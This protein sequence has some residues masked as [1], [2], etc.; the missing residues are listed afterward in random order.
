MVGIMNPNPNPNP[1][2]DKHDHSDSSSS[3]GIL[4][5]A[6]TN[7]RRSTISNVQRVPRNITVRAQAG[8]PNLLQAI[9]NVQNV[10]HLPRAVNIVQ[11]GSEPQNIHIL[12]IQGI[13]NQLQL[14]ALGNPW[15]E[16][17]HIS[18]STV[19]SLVMANSLIQ[20]IHSIPRTEWTQPNLGMRPL[21]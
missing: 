5:N 12:G 14:Q 4:L 2:P 6:E 20:K 1:N 18:A 8:E 21:R 9:P 10:D 17:W 7:L 13:D 11:G 16:S 19:C 15:V 3:S